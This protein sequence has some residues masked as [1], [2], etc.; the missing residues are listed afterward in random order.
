LSHDTLSEDYQEA[1]AAIALAEHM[2][3]YTGQQAA[4]F[5]AR[6]SDE[7]TKKFPELKGTSREK[8]SL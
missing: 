8:R 1:V 7:L 2:Q 6:A 4:I 5:T 3:K